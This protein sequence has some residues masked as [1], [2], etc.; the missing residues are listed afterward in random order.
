MEKVKKSKKKI[1]IAIIVI[2]ILVSI[3]SNFFKKEDVTEPEF[4][5]VA[6]EKQTQQL[7]LVVQEK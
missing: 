7:Q 4:D 2:L 1:I 3:I 5:T 6:I